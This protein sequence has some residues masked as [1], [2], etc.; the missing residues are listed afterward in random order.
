MATISNW[1]EYLWLDTIFYV[2][3]IYGESHRHSKWLYCGDNEDLTV[4]S[5]DIDIDGKSGEEQS[6]QSE[7]SCCHMKAD[8]SQDSGLELGDELSFKN[9]PGTKFN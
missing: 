8:Q 6:E 4:F 3:G 9:M 2:L 7:T 1:V 5:I